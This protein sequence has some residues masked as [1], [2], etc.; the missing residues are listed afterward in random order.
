MGPIN[1]LAMC[2]KVSQNTP[3]QEHSIVKLFLVLV[4]FCSLFSGGLGSVI[5]KYF[6]TS[7]WIYHSLVKIL[8]QID[9]KFGYIFIDTT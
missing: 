9:I 4:E 3:T 7:L 2:A 6:N 1:H 8:F 5:I